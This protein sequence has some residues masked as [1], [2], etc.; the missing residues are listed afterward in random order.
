MFARIVEADLRS[1]QLGLGKNLEENPPRK[2]KVLK[3]IAENRFLVENI[4][5]DP[6]KR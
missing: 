2:D 4:N 1:D 3:P 6:R 5:I